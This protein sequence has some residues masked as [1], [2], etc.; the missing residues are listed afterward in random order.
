MEFLAGLERTPLS[1]FMREDL[2]AFPATLVAH[3]LG[4]G[5]LAGAGVVTG[6][7]AIS[8]RTTPLWLRPYRALLDI[9]LLIA[10]I[11]GLLLLTA[12]PA[13]ALTNGVF[14]IKISAVAVA[15][16]L[17]AAALERSVSRPVRTGLVIVALWAI[18]IFS[19]RLLAYTHHVLLVS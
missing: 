12:Y 4:M 5:L 18:G 10:L 14:W 13:K 8:S 6:L 2:V 17:S 9:G 19:G 1:V 7:I 3:A 11:S 16:R 15:Y